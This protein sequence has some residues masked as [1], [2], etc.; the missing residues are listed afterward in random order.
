MEIFLNLSVQGKWKAPMIANPAYK[1]KWA[2]R[3]V[4]NPDYFEDAT[5]WKM[6]PFHAVGF[7]LWTLSNDIYFDNILITSDEA[8]AANIA[9]KVRYHN[10]CKIFFIKISFSNR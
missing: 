4:P 6:T 10:F 9:D 5:P 8:D 7:E 3:K 2:P 1:G